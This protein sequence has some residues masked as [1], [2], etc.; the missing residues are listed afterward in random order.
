MNQAERET[1]EDF[2]LRQAHRVLL[3][4][5]L[6]FDIFQ[7]IQSNRI[8]EKD[9]SFLLYLA[10]SEETELRHCAEEYMHPKINRLLEN[11]TAVQK[12]LKK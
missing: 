4:E 5:L 10:F 3:E 11:V 9:R 6:G 7:K 8:N 12:I 2:A 1:V